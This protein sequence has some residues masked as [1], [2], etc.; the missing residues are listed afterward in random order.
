MSDSSIISFRAIASA[1]GL[2]LDASHYSQRRKEALRILSR[3]G[4]RLERLKDVTSSVFIPP[5]FKRNYVEAEYGIPFLQGSHVVHWRPAGLQFLARSTPRL[6][7]WLVQAGWLLITCSGTVGRTLLCP[8]EWDDWAASQHIL[9]IIPDEERC[10][11]GYLCAFLES[12]LG[13]AQLKA[14]IHGAVVDELTDVHVKDVMVPV[15]ETADEWELVEKLDG[16]VKQATK[17]KSEA[18]A[19]AEATAAQI[20]VWLQQPIETVDSST[21]HL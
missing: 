15:P 5:R 8:P 9:R 7:R 12:P 2:R 20:K 4:M 16:G 17:L 3:S 13:Q 6:E 14:N 10:P 19:V 1:D 21:E 18:V 11:A